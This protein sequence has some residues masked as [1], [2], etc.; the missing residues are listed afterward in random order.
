MLPLLQARRPHVEI[1]LVGARPA[2]ALRRLARNRR[3]VRL[4]GPVADMPLHLSRAAVAV[5]PMRAGSG[6]Q[7]KI[8][9]A[10][11]CGTPVV[12]TSLAAAGLDAIAG[13]DLLVANDA[14]G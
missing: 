10:M 14:Q 9:E 1:D 7:M 5:V 12:A 2:A 6:Q 4:V 11:G 8:L 13:R 3:G